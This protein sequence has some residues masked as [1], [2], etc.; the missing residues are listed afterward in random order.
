MMFDQFYNPKECLARTAEGSD[1][2]GHEWYWAIVT[3]KTK[4][5]QLGGTPI[6]AILTTEAAIKNNPK[7][8][9]DMVIVPA[10]RK[11]DEEVQSKDS[12]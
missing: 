3:N 6:E 12:R 4:I 8:F 1:I 9:A 10:Y 11:E 7:H 2:S 5:K